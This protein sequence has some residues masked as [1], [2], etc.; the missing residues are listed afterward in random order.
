MSEL[1]ELRDKI[2]GMKNKENKLAE[3]ASGANAIK[4]IRY[5]S[6]RAEAFKEVLVEMEDMVMPFDIDPKEWKY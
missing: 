5:H 6:N 3:H 1:S 2:T 4:L